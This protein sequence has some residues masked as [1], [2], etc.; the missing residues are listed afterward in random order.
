MRQFGG[1]RAHFRPLAWGTSTLVAAT[2]LLSVASAPAA[3]ADS[4]SN[5][6]AEA[7]ALAQKINT[8]EA[9]VNQLDDQ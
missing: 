1:A 8:E 3:H 4:L 6:Q 2:M 7:A 5:D 9:Q